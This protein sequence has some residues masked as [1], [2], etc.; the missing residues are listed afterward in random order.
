MKKKSISILGSTGSV[1]S[2]TIDIV[3][4]NLDKF[5]V[6]GLTAKDNTNLLIKQSCLVKPK[7]VAIHNKKKYKILKNELFGKK[8]KVLVDESSKTKR[9][10][11]THFT[12]SVPGHIWPENFQIHQI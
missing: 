6:C 1:G 4:E 12:Q 11:T 10:A 9:G 5:S 2:N 8:I 7:V 3:A